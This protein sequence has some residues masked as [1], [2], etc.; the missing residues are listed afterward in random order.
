M[1]HQQCQSTITYAISK[2]WIKPAT[3]HLTDSQINT[4]SKQHRAE[5]NKEYKAKFIAKNLQLGLTKYGK[6]RLRKPKMDLSGWTPEQKRARRLE[7]LRQWNID[8]RGKRN[9]H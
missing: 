7:M 4:L 6:P 9:E 2:G 5:K 1:T 3:S 8:N